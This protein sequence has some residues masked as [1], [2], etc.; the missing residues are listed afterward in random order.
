MGNESDIV[1]ISIKHEN[2]KYSQNVLNELI[3]VFN[4]DG[5]ETDSLYTKELLI[6]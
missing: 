2:K 4:Q 3:D 5:F 1:Q 6:L